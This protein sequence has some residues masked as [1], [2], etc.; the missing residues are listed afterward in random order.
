MK[1]TINEA[2][3]HHWALDAQAAEVLA[4]RIDDSG[5]NSMLERAYEGLDAAAVAQRDSNRQRIADIYTGRSDE[6]FVAIGPCSLDV[7]IDYDPLF[8]YIGMLQEEHPGALI[9]LRANGAKPR[10]STGWTG[11]W[12]S[13]DPDVR[14][15]HFDIYK[16]AFDRGLPIIT[17]ITEGNQLGALGPMLSSVWMGARDVEPTAH[18][19]KF[20]AYHLPVGIKNGT[21]GDLAI[22]ENTI[23]AVRSNTKLNDGSGVDLGTIASNPHSPGIATGI[24]PVGEGNPHAAIFARGYELPEGMTA[25]ERKAAAF[26]YISRTNALGKLLGNAVIIDGTHSVPPMFDIPR[27]HADRFIPVLE[28]IHQGMRDGSIEDA[29]QLVGVMGEVGIVEG[30][31]DPNYVLDDERKGILQEALR[32]TLEHL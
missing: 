12:Y 9:A 8:D 28:V 6:K 5:Q 23:K 29:D 15:R 20:S 1:E 26:D 3:V 32:L 21:T 18:R 17:E 11:L 2:L 4:D 31:T 7:E 30:R 27:K 25:E 14:Q 13:P 10:T 24:V 22:V 19:G 16:D